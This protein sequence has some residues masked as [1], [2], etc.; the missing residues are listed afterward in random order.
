MILTSFSLQKEQVDI[1]IDTV[2]K[3]LRQDAEYQNLLRELGVT[4]SALPVK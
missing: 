3:V 4:S 2:K 1:L